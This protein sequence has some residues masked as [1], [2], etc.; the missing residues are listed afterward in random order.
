MDSELNNPADRGTLNDND[1]S[2]IGLCGFSNMGNTC[3]LNSV[4]QL[5]IHSNVFLSFLLSK[6]N[7]YNYYLEKASIKHIS[8]LYRKQNNLSN[9]AQITIKRSDIDRI[10]KLSIIGKLHEIVDLIINK[11]NCIIIP[12]KFKEVIDLKI[13]FFRNN[14]QHDAHE[15]LLKVLDNIIEETGIETNKLVLNNVPED[16]KNYEEFLKNSEKKI[17]E[18]DDIN[19]KKNIN[20]YL[21]KFKLEN[22]NTVNQYIGLHYMKELFNKKYNSFIYNVTSVVIDYIKCSNCNNLIVKPSTNT[23]ITLQVTDNLY[24]SFV[25]FTKVDEVEYKCECCNSPE[26]RAFKNC[27][28]LKPPVLLFIHLKRFENHPNGR[29]FK[30]N[31][32]VDIP[33]EFDISHFYDNSIINTNKFNKYKLKGIVNHHGGLNSG[34]YTA[35]CVCI[36][37]DSWFHFD[38]SNV[39]I[40]NGKRINISSAYILMYE[41]NP[42]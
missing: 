36:N 16:I 10:M 33:H 11:G 24:N 3:Y 32:F 12:Q 2:K 5:L 8:K 21:N 41:M 18:T 26:K 17:S 30:N 9:D 4:L 1:I 28:I 39:S 22:K 20:E 15:F 37:D 7:N 6:N 34:H 14:S 42:E 13:K 27:K 35:D 25:E 38:D 23:I 19:E 29:T 40:Y 31:S